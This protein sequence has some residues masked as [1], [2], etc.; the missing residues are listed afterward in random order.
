MS[1]VLV[2]AGLV[3][4]VAGAEF[5]VKGASR[6]AGVAGISPL[7]IGLTVVAFGTSAPEMAVSVGAAWNGSADLALGNVVGSNVFNILFI[8]GLSALIAPLVVAQ[9]LVRLDVPL[10]IAASIVVWLM[11]LDGVVARWEGALLFTGVVTYTV[12]LIRQSRRERSEAVLAE[13]EQEFA[14]ADQGKQPVWLNGVFIVA[15]LIG[16]VLGSRLLVQGAVAIAQY[17]GV[18]EL[19][20]G[21]TIV[22][23][24]TSM[25]EVAT[26][27]VASI[28]GERDIAVGNVVGSNLFNLLAVLG[29]AGALSVNGIAVSDKALAV[30]IPVMVGA[31]VIC[32]PVFITG[33][34]ISRWNGLTF[35]AL[36]LAYMLY[37]VLDAQGASWIG[38]YDDVLLHFVVPVTGFVMISAAMRYLFEGD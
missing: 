36:Y 35:L 31:A 34:V 38:T 16:L 3:L 10:M 17:F 14:G 7:I 18:S 9:Q 19:V 6:L 8:L 12:F 23:I 22:S 25:P 21:L 29:A 30:D 4:L 15:G 1:I 32:L 5:L 27:V 26:S 37:L 24:G 11:A 13:Y 33:F 20:I 2:V 28:R